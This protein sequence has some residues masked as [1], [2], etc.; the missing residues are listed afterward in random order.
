MDDQYFHI[1]LCEFLVPV[2]TEVPSISDPEKLS[3]Q[4]LLRFDVKC[5]KTQQIYKYRVLKLYHISPMLSKKCSSSLHR[6]HFF[7]MN[8]YPHCSTEFGWSIKDIFVY[9]GSHCHYYSVLKP[10]MSTLFSMRHFL[11][12]IPTPILPFLNRYKENSPTANDR[13][14]YWK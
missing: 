10:D 14:I 3:Y 2:L 5:A 6:G 11:T 12:T 1:L 9:Q 13:G 8:S 4:P 7:K